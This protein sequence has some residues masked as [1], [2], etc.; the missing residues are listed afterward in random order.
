V[1]PI[2]A[3]DRTRLRGGGRRCLWRRRVRLN[4]IG[5]ELHRK[6]ILG[7]DAGAVHELKPFA[8]DRQA[9]RRAIDNAAAE[10]IAARLDPTRDM[11]LLPVELYDRLAADGERHHDRIGMGFDVE[12][13]RA[14]LVVEPLG[15]PM[16]PVTE[17]GPDRLDLLLEDFSE[18]ILQRVSIDSWRRGAPNFR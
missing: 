16:A 3:L 17:T 6:A 5:Q 1:R 13:M 11:L 18:P 4:Q 15:E 9:D 2:R 10:R 7:H 12:L 8:V 14:D